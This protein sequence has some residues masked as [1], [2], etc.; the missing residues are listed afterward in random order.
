MSIGV[1]RLTEAGNVDTDYGSWGIMAEEG[2]AASS[3]TMYGIGSC[4]KAI[5]ASAVGILMDDFAQ[6]HNVVPLPPNLAEFTWDTRIKDLFP[7]GSEWRLPDSWMY[8]VGSHIIATYSGMPYTSFV[9]KRIFDPLGLNTTTFFADEAQLTGHLS[10]S[11]SI[12]ASGARRRVPFW[13]K[14]ESVE[15]MA[16]PGGVIS[17]AKDM[18]K[19]LAT[20]LKWGVDPYTNRSIFPPSVYEETSTA[21]SLIS[22]KGSDPNISIQGYGLV[23]ERFSLREHEVLLYNG[24]MPGFLTFI[25]LVPSAKVGVVG[26]TNVDGDQDV[27]RNIPLRILE[28]VLRLSYRLPSLKVL[29]GLMS[30]PLPYSTQAPGTASSPVSSPTDIDIFVGMYTNPGY[31]SLDLCSPRSKTRYCLPVLASFSR[32]GELDAKDRTLYAA[33]PRVWTSHMSMRH[34]GNG[35]FTV[36]FHTLF[37]NG[38]GWDTTPF[39]HRALLGLNGGYL[40]ESSIYNGQVNGFGL[41]DVISYPEGPRTT[42]GSISKRADVWFKKVLPPW[43]AH[44]AGSDLS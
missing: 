42:R 35:I 12:S 28:N 14:A 8:M 9:K 3:A 10:Q 15:A 36:S 38:L 22:G 30:S 24:P 34:R 29:S 17:T 18:T 1:V 40:A 16:R 6:G 32:C 44:V 13:F 26:L 43:Y 19:W 20:V 7:G 11:W 4:S 21:Q 5:L 33:W 23:W 39:V 27:Y 37:P 25:V 41:M 31:G 2:E